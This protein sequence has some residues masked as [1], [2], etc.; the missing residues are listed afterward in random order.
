MKCFTYLIVHCKYFPR[1][2]SGDNL[3]VDINGTGTSSETSSVNDVN[4]VDPS[5]TPSLSPTLGL[6]IV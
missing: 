6:F 4:E 3:L 2:N 5:L 1:T